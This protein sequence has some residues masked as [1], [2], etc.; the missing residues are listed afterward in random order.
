MMTDCIHRFFSW[1]LR[2]DRLSAPFFFKVSCRFRLS[3]PSAAWQSETV[4]LLE[5]C[6]EG[7]KGVF[8]GERF[9]PRESFLG[10]KAQ[11]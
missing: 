5:G 1:G 11:E 7:E 8:R 2:V 10:E 9:S 4:S 6:L 3:E